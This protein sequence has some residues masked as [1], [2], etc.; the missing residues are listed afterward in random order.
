MWGGA[1]DWWVTPRVAKW[2]HHHSPEN[3]PGARARRLRWLRRARTSHLPTVQ[4]VQS[5]SSIIRQAS[6]R[7][8]D[9]PETSDTCPRSPATS[10]GSRSSAIVMPE[11]KALRGCDTGRLPDRLSDR[12]PSQRFHANMRASRCARI[13]DHDTS[14]ARGK[15]FQRNMETL[16]ALQSGFTY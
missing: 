9:A 11:A 7:A 10:Y 5:G 3:G 16:I 8:R 2:S 4:H 14:R 12:V 13:Q 1:G 15:T 6:G